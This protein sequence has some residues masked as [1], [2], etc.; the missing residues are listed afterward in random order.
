MDHV[1]LKWCASLLRGRPV[2]LGAGV[3]DHRTADSA[4]PLRTCMNAR[5]FLPIL[6]PCTFW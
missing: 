2:R 1:G 3:V 4:E 6:L 5:I